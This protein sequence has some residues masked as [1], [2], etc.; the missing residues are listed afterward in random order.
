MN[1]VSRIFFQRL[2]QS[3]V[4]AL[5]CY[6]CVVL[7]FAV[8]QTYSQKP[9]ENLYEQLPAFALQRGE[10]FDTGFG[11]SEDKDARQ[12]HEWL[13]LH[14]PNT[15]EIPRGIQQQEIAFT[16]SIPSKEEW[17]TDMY[18][19]TKQVPRVQSQTWTQLGPNN[20]GGRTR[21]LA[22][23]VDNPNT[24]IAG[25]VSGGLWRTVDGGR[26]WRK[27]TANW[28][29]HSVSCIVQDPR[30]GKRNIWYAGTGEII[31]N[32][33]GI[34][35]DGLFKSVDGGITWRPIVSTVGNRPEV[36][37]SFWDYVFEVA[38]DPTN[39]DQDEVYA[40]TYGCIYRS[41]NGGT[42][43]TRVLGDS[44]PQSGYSTYSDIIVTPQG[45]K[46]AYL[47][48]GGRNPGVWRSTDG[49]TW[50]NITPSGFPP[51][52]Q[53]MVLTFAPS[54]PNIV[55]ILGSTP[56]SGL[57][58]SYAGSAESNSLWRYQYQSGT[59]AGSGG[60]WTNVSQNMPN[61]ANRSDL[62]YISQGGY[63]I[64]V[65][66][67]PD[68]PNTVL[69]G[70][71]WSFRSTDGFST[72]NNVSQ[73]TTYSQPTDPGSRRPRDTWA[74]NHIF[75][76]APSDNNM[77]YVGNDGGVWRTRN[78]SA[79]DSIVYE[80]LNNGYITTQFYTVAI[81]KSAPNDRTVVGGLQDNGTLMSVAGSNNFIRPF[82]GDGA[83]CAIGAQK[84]FYVMSSQQ[85][86]IYRLNLDPSG[87]ILQGFAFLRPVVTTNATFRF[88]HPFALDANDT[89]VFYLPYG[90]Q[91]WRHN[92]IT[93]IPQ[94]NSPTSAGWNRIAFL[95]F[96]TTILS[97]A[98][99]TTP[100]NVLYFGTT[101]GRIWRVDNAQTA[102][103]QV[104]EVTGSN[105]PRNTAGQNIGSINCIAV[106]SRDAN[107]V[108][109]V[110]SNYG[111][112]SLFYSSNG[113][114]SWVSVAGNLEQNPDGTGAGPA[115][116]WANI[117]NTPNG[118]IF[119]VATSTGVYSTTR[120]QDDD[121]VGTKTLWVR[122]GASTIGQTPCNMLDSRESDGFVAVGS[123]GNGI[124]TTT[125]N[126]DR[127]NQAQTDFLNPV[128][129]PITPNPA[130]NLATVNF[131]LPKRGMVSLRLF[132]LQGR[133]VVNPVRGEYP[134]GENYVDINVAAIAQGFY[135][136]RL[137]VDGMALTQSLIV[138]K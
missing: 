3:A 130:S 122:E 34:T 98:S 114:A 99:S 61:T 132:D 68:D 31:G 102:T 76:F 44:I 131:Y 19:S 93:T 51:N 36:F 127:A 92:D 94:T 74:D 101:G 56:N 28:L 55:Y 60:T 35:G 50:T 18:R 115:V 96:V 14:D 46:Y 116:R 40:A 78:V 128:L 87:T 83:Y 138:V 43:W 33:A 7:G 111:I 126:Y 121:G 67:K 58:V 54:N 17:M 106:D 8:Y 49:V 2:S 27:V 21:A 45:V 69:I 75:L 20:V 135:T 42:T 41:L 108:L 22:I 9:Q 85:G 53:S 133:E 89:K 95:P 79:R 66:V 5:C 38:I 52:T 4:I 29:L 109:A 100:A 88:I 118:Q 113:G 12:E 119:L 13:L 72:P 10:G 80:S 134:S 107:R 81:D 57:T 73:A 30:P 103:P 47:S 26:T 48:T 63:N 125:L 123:H 11:E 136:Y 24:I 25:G 16:A 129:R 23:D 86:N 32:S 97:V 1:L 84:Q 104:R 65:R 105:F 91:L 117:V 90:N 124:F 71:V 70:G 6:G 77:M 112:R 59:G 64:T 120:L 137:E 15:G 62:T 37:E 39:A 110:F 82:G